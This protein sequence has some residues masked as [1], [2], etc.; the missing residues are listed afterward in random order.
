MRSKSARS[1]IVATAPNAGCEPTDMPPPP[2]PFANFVAALERGRV[3]SAEDGSIAVWTDFPHERAIASGLWLVMVGLAKRWNV[4]LTTE[5]SVANVAERTDILVN[6]GLAVGF[7]SPEDVVAAWNKSVEKPIERAF[8]L[9]YR[10]GTDLP[11]AA[12]QELAAGNE[13]AFIDALATAPKGAATGL[14]GVW[15]K[16]VASFFVEIVKAARAWAGEIDEALEGFIKRNTI[17][18]EGLTGGAFTYLG[19]EDVRVVK[20]CLE[21]LAEAEAVEKEEKVNGVPKRYFQTP[22]TKAGLAFMYARLP[23][24][25]LLLASGLR[26]IELFRKVPHGYSSKSRA[27]YLI[28]R[29]VANEWLGTQIVL[30]VGGQRDRDHVSEKEYLAALVKLREL[31]NE[32]VVAAVMARLSGRGMKLSVKDDTCLRAEIV[33]RLEGN[34]EFLG[35]RKCS[36]EPRKRSEDDPGYGVIIRSAKEGRDRLAIISDMEERSVEELVA[37]RRSASED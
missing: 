18:R 5:R 36:T 28:G 37:V 23:A 16:P 20:S 11:L 4:K 24:I 3:P 8:V 34:R 17:R 27:S 22:L 31:D 14:D 1:L 15:Q 12:W 30:A 19:E 13:D 9:G 33:G 26:R 6:A 2:T 10:P 29:T 25:K 35:L 21:T 7:S 32:T